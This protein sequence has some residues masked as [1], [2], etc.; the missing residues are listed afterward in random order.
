MERVDARQIERLQVDI[1]DAVAL[2]E[3]MGNDVAP[4]LA[5]STSEDDAFGGHC[6]FTLPWK[7]G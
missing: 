5:G 3:Q 1:E 2:E 4:S 7:Q 6:G